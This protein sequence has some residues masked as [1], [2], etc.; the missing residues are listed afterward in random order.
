M[1]RHVT[2]RRGEI[3]GIAGVAGNGQRELWRAD[4]AGPAAD[5]RVLLDGQDITRLS[6]RERRASGHG[7][8]SGG[9]VPVGIGPGGVRRRHRRDGPA[10]PAAAL[11]PGADRP[12]GLA[13]GRAAAIVAEYRVRTRPARTRAG[14]LSGGN[15]QKLVVGP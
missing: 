9:P 10:L 15:L 2:V 4:G 7:S 1:R 13:A 14:A 5:G 12:V 8:R 3:V 11:P 6:V